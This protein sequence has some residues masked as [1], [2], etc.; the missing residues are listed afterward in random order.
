[1]GIS[2]HA[3]HMCGSNSVCCVTSQNVLEYE[4]KPNDQGVNIVKLT[5]PMGTFDY[6]HDLLALLFYD[7][8]LFTRCII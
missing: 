2:S 3:L 1:M 5:E 6:K 4:R 8:K 7:N